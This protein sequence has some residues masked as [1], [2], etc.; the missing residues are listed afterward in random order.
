LNDA[1]IYG[2][3]N[4]P[5]AISVPPLE[6]PQYADVLGGSG[7]TSGLSSCVKFICPAPG[8]LWDGTTPTDTNGDGIYENLDTDPLFTMND[9]ILY[10]NHMDWIMNPATEP[11]CAFDVNHNGRIDFADIVN[12]YGEVH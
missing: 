4:D 7:S 8:P 3:S 10:F 2:S 6:T 1:F 9:V 5:S 11:P 12:L